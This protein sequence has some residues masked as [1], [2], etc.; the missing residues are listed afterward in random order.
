MATGEPDPVLASDGTGMA[1]PPVVVGGPVM[2]PP[3]REVLVNDVLT[4]TGDEDLSVELLTPRNGGTAT[5]SPPTP[6]NTPDAP[7]GQAFSGAQV[8]RQARDLH[9]LSLF[10]GP[11][12]R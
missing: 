7:F 8:K 4:G 1:E 2:A 11:L 6:T 9:L 3:G 10:H 12:G 5:A